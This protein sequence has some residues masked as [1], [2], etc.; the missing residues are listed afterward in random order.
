VASISA[1][2]SETKLAMVEA[3]HSSLPTLPDMQKEEG[4]E[5]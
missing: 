2:D 1:R 5:K 3:T 4:K